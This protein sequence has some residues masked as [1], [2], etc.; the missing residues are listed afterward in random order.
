MRAGNDDERQDTLANMDQRQASIRAVTHSLEPEVL[1]PVQN[2][3]VEPRPSLQYLAAQ[4][5][6]RLTAEGDILCV[7]GS[8]LFISPCRLLCAHGL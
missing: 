1:V 8:E 3:L 7:N 5:E 2:V 4:C 6:G